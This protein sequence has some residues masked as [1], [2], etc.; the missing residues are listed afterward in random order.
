MRSRISIA[1]FLFV[2]VGLN[3]NA[4]TP[5]RP[6]A[7]SETGSIRGRVTAAA[8]GKPVRRARVTIR[9][10][11]ETSGAPPITANTNARGEF[12]ALSVPPGPYFISAAR[13]GF[14]TTQ[15]GQRRPRERG[16]T[17]D[18]RAGRVTDGVDFALPA[19]GVLAGQVTDELGE[20][21]PGVRVDAMD[22]RYDGGR[23]QP[24]PAGVSITDD[25][26]RFRISGLQPGSYYVMAATN[27]TW[28]TEKKEVYGYASTYFPGVAAREAPLIP[29]AAG[30]ERNDLNFTLTISRA[31]RVS[32][33]VLRRTGEPLAGGSVSLMYSYPGSVV[34]TSGAR[35]VRTEADG[36]FEFRD[37]PAARYSL[38]TTGSSIDVSV[39][40]S[41]VEDLVLAQKVGSTVTGSVITDD[42]GVP[43]F[44]SSGVRV[45]LVA[46]GDN[47]LPTVYVN[48]VNTDWTF[49]LANLGGPF[50]FRIR[51]IPADWTLAAV[52]LNDKEITDVPWDV[53]ARG[54]ELSGLQIVVTQ[55]IGRV[56]GTVADSRGA[57]TAAATVV[58]FSDEP[59]LWIP[60]S[61]FVRMTRPGADGTFAISGLPPAAYRAIA[62]DFIEEGQWEDRKFL[63][64]ARADAIRF[65]LS[66]GGS[67]TIILRLPPPR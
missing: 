16:L 17:V 41:D 64:E 46:G 26:G 43:A 44:P 56:S 59:E 63:E 12:E 30:Q 9:T 40:G 3:P 19:G 21:F 8:T 33:R 54:E 10:A 29:L 24:F 37:V 53:P 67:E 55:R 7:A 60:G 11:E 15:Y 2:T 6:L 27:E 42:G 1:A 38:A 58:I 4:Q 28:R 23:R 18:V 50:M 32:G 66:D 52:R 13:A 61:R 48:A 36:S 35:S 5:A 51:G 14:V 45:T 47:V 65:S 34:M 39:D 22:M 62:R 25:L 31:A 57:A 49:K 20:P